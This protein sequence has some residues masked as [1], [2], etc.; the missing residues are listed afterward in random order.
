MKTKK[1]S[2]IKTSWDENPLAILS[3]LGEVL[4]LINF[5]VTFWFTINFETQKQE[6]YQSL[7]CSSPEIKLLTSVNWSILGLFGVYLFFEKYMSATPNPASVLGVLI[8]FSLLG[9][10]SVFVHYSIHR[11][12]YPQIEDCLGY[13]WNQL[14]VWNHIQVWSMALVSPVLGCC[15]GCFRLSRHNED[16]DE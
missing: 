16:D 15:Y 6:N 8:G 2:V 14:Q 5:V 1:R 9:L 11:A 3:I 13:S 4:K 12:E 7:S 10:R